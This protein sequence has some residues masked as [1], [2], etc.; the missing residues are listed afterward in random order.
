[1]YKLAKFKATNVLGFISGIGKKTFELELSKFNDK[2]LIVIFGDNASGK[3]T[4][5]SLVHPWYLPVDGRTKFIAPGKEGT[6]LREYHGDDGTII[7]TK[8][9]YRPKSK[10]EDG[11]HTPKCYLELTR[12][13][14]EPVE[15]NPTGNVTSYV[16]LLY[17]YFGITKDFISFATYNSAVAGIIKMTDTER[18][19]SVS[20]LVPN[21]AR[22]EVAY[23]TIND[24]YRELRNLIRNV[25]QKILNLRDEA[26]LRSDLKRITNEVDT[27][28]KD[29]EDAL[30]KLSKAEGRLKE[31]T[32]GADIDELVAEYNQMVASIDICDTEI[33]EIQRRLFQLYSIMNIE[34]EPGS[35]Q[36]AGIDSTS[37]NVIRYERKVAK[38]DAA[39]SGYKDRQSSLKN[40]LFSVETEIEENEAL[41]YSVEDQDIGELKRLRTEYE[42]QINSLLY[43]KHKDKYADMSYDEVVN[44]SRVINMLDV[45]IQAMYDEYG[46]LVTEYFENI[47]SGDY[48]ARQSWSLQTLHATIESNSEKKDQIYRRLIELEQ[49]RKFQAILDQR[50]KTCTIDTCPFIANALKWSQMSDEVERLKA[51][52]AGLEIQIDSDTKTAQEYEKRL[53]LNTDIQTLLTYIKQQAPLIKKYY[54]LELTDVYNSIQHATWNSTLSILPL[55]DYAAILS[56]KDLY[57]KIT[58]QSIPEVEHSIEMAKLY[59]TNRN[60]I[61]SQLERLK[62]EKK[63]LK[64]ELSEYGIHVH[65]S[66]DSLRRYRKMLHNWRELDEL[67]HLYKEAMHARI[68]ATSKAESRADDIQTIKELRDKV[69]SNRYVIEELDNLIRQRNP[70]QQQLK[71][72]LLSLDQLKIEKATIERDFL[73]VDV[74]RS[75]IQP[76]KG[77]RKELINI[78]MYDIYQTANQLLLN[79]FNGNLYLKEFIITDKEFVI[80][81]VYNGTEGPDVS[82]ASASQQSDITIA[83]SMAILSKILSDYG[84]VGFDEADAPFSPANRE[85][86]IDILT[87]QMRLIGIS[88]AFFITQ[89]PEDYEGYDVGFLCFPG[90]K[91][92]KKG[93]DI[94]EIT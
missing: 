52:Y 60:M 8:C 85:V 91:I 75:I 14:A 13:G 87:T 71:L 83:I 23:N 10:D 24:K 50:P 94:I 57:I 34:H 27:Y 61:K 25:S 79:T 43:T 42:E 40:S 84:I 41:L 48:A 12:P 56:E 36:F 68:T 6:V 4:F 51:E 86:F 45:M 7:V 49:Y 53:G 69:K 54:N 46:E 82:F 39:L 2:D 67:I 72:D 77:L 76:G 73:I 17:T 63:R 65:V 15:M 22:F 88:Q 30:K 64:E 5:L 90:G 16:S 78:Y 1:M 35:V 28:L 80:P 19:N 89:N 70:V 44:F 66:A 31:L 93:K 74:M 59:G 81:Y 11:G 62:A 18:K 29:R 9:V 55:K 32:R 20:T 3:S 47:D 37:N 38:L 58:T 26:S 21:T 92:K 33:A